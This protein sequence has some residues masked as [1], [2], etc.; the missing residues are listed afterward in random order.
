VLL[1]GI[2]IE[3]PICIMNSRGTR[4]FDLLDET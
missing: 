3:L 1:N 4:S 2:R